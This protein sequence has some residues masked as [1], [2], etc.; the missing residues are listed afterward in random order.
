MY[1]S[2]FT[3]SSMRHRNTLE[4]KFRRTSIWRRNEIIK[5]NLCCQEK[6]ADVCVRLARLWIYL[7][8]WRHAIRNY[9]FL[10]GIPVNTVVFLSIFIR[11]LSGGHNSMSEDRSQ[12]FRELAISS[13]NE[14]AT[15][16]VIKSSVNLAPG[17]HSV[18]NH[19]KSY[20][21][22]RGRG[23]SHEGSE[24]RRR[25]RWAIPI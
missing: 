10:C 3:H 15:W 17:F 22:W 24:L 13:H 11:H 9:T 4:A 21:A 18:F 14:N 5:A 7:M 16:Y 1:K 2:P 25:Q 8:W 19:S 23:E 12:Q 20:R 6:T